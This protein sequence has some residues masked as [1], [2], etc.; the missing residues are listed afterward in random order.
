LVLAGLAALL[1]SEPAAGVDSGLLERVQPTIASTP[2]AR[3]T[4]TTGQIA[5]RLMIV[6]SQE[7]DPERLPAV[8][9]L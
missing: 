8:R 3:L 1:V 9:P 7:I 2:A 5:V 6:L 4:P